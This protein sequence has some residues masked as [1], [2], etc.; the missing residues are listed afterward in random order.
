MQPLG[1]NSPSGI[2]KW[3]SEVSWCLCHSEPSGSPRS[4][5]PWKTSLSLTITL[6]FEGYRYLRSVFL[7]GL[8]PSEV[9]PIPRFSSPIP[10][11]MSPVSFLSTFKH[12][13]ALVTFPSP[14]VLHI[15]SSVYSLP[16]SQNTPKHD[17]H[18]LIPF[19]HL[20]LNQIYWTPATINLPK[21]A[22]KK[23]TM[24][25]SCKIQC[26]LMSLHLPWPFSWI[27]NHQILHSFSKFS[28]PFVISYML[29]VPYNIHSWFSSNVTASPP[30]FPENT[31][32]CVAMLGPLLTIR[33]LPR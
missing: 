23:S 16:Y 22:L 12:A 1:I 32:Q 17:L 11:S 27:Q 29:Y 10:T 24:L 9:V 33:I 28:L 4:R 8:I 31:S 3:R 30:Q 5:I 13:H 2:Q 26:H 15:L 7:P 20:P 14:Y 21:K 25:F 6:Q 18:L 19:T